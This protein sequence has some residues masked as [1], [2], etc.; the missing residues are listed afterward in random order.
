[1]LN[2]GHADKFEIISAA[3]CGISNKFMIIYVFINGMK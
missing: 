2:V 1:M 3:I